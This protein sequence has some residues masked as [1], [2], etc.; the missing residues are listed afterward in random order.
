V[1]DPEGGERRRFNDD[2]RRQFS[3]SGRPIAF[4]CECADGGCRTTVPLT[5]EE[6]DVRRPGPIVDASHAVVVADVRVQPTTS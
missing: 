2:R 4:V 1:A 5:P 3:T 6:Y